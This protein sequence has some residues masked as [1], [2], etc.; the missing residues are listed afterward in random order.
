MAE[1]KNVE[2]LPYGL[3]VD[4]VFL[5]LDELKK[6]P[7]STD[8][9]LGLRVGKSYQKAKNAAIEL[10]L[11]SIENNQPIL[12]S[13]GKH[14]AWEINEVDKKKLILSCIIQNFRPYEI[15]L[16]RMVREEK[17]TIPTEF[18]QQLWAREMNFKL[19]EDNLARAVSFFFQLLDLTG[20]GN[21]FI[22]RHGQKT[23]FS[24]IMG[25]KDF[26]NN[27]LQETPEPQRNN[28]PEE[29][30]PVK[31]IIKS[32]ETAKK[33]ENKATEKPTPTSTQGNDETTLESDPNWSILKTDYF[34]L[35]I[36]NRPDVWDLLYDMI[37]LYRKTLSFSKKQNVEIQSQ[38][39]D[40]KV[41]VTPGE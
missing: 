3:A 26:V 28:D 7:S 37:P 2:T 18:V 5:V 17:D 19:S 27:N 36:Q 31:D 35:K 25:A 34:I 12:S 39:N 22:G 11:I 41:D 1:E 6:R 8:D 32:T 20:L 4:N 10:N 33:S 23:R 14:I 16:S 24:F 29:A 9:E 13:T 15:A 40:T 30:P 38:P 21:T